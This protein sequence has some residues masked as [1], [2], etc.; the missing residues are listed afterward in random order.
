MACHAAADRE[1]RCVWLGRKIESG[2]CY[3]LRREGD[4]AGYAVFEYSFF[5]LGFITLLWTTANRR[6]E[7]VATALIGYLEERCQTAKIFTSTNRSNHPMR[8]LLAKLNYVFSGEVDNLD[9]G[10]PELFFCKR[11]AP[12]ASA[13]GLAGDRIDHP[14]NPE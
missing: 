7:G 2:N 4:V 5:D 12:A 9:V 14:R 3:L 11:L 10:D 6:Q 13:N 1:D 8:A